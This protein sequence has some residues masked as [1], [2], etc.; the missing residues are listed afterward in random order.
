MVQ[1]R[2]SNFSPKI[3]DISDDK[4]LYGV[5]EHDPRYAQLESNELVRRQLQKLQETIKSFNKQS[6]KQT[7][8]MIWLTWVML[9]L[10]VAMLVGLIIQIIIAF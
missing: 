4:L 6:S 8:K 1:N 2:M 9:I 7:D 3:E 5:N 10:T